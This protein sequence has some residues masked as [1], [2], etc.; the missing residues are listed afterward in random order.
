MLTLQVPADSRV[1]PTVR[2]LATTLLESFHV[3]PDDVYDV[4]LVLGEICSN[5]VRHAYDDPTETYEV[6]LNFLPEGLG[7]TVTDHGRGLSPTSR[8]APDPHRPNGWGLWLVEHLCDHVSVEPAEPHGTRV[9]ARLS[10][11]YQPHCNGACVSAN[12]TVDLQS[13]HKMS[14]A[15][16]G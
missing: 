11:R 1:V 13:E 4:N 16:T 3:L 14:Q 15:A 6:A 9:T 5:V 8:R 2:A 12:H 7:I 10:L